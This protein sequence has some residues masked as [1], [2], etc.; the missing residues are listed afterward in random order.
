MKTKFSP[1]LKVRKLEIE[2]I[3]NQLLSYKNQKRRAKSK[4]SNLMDDLKKMEIAKKGSITELKRSFFLISSLQ[5]SIAQKKEYINLLDN[6]I[7]STQ[8]LLQKATI[9]YEKIKYLHDIEVKKVLEK[10]KKIEI[11]ELDEVA[12][13]LF[14]TRKKR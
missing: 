4:L 12:S 2:K 11:K 7:K 14:G 6:Q 1:I 10:I 5:N 8:K 3:E 9:E 13:Q